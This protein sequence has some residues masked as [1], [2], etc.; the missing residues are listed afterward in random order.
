MPDLKKLE[1][2]QGDEESGGHKTATPEENLQTVAQT[3]LISLKVN[4]DSG[5]LVMSSSSVQLRLYVLRD[6]SRTTSTTA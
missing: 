4:E 2:K 6:S 3:S 1:L 5:E